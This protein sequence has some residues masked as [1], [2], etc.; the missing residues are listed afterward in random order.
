MQIL[1]HKNWSKAM[2]KDSWVLSFS[3]VHMSSTLVR[4]LTV[5]IVAL[6][7]VEMHSFP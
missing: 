4:V 2:I 5:F 6:S 1:P 3:D 7:S